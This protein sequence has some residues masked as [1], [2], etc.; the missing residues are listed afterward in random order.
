MTARTMCP[1]ETPA[2]IVFVACDVPTVPAWMVGEAGSMVDHLDPDCQHIRRCGDVRPTLD[3]VCPEGSD[4]CGTCVRRW[5]AK[6]RA[7]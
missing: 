3:R 2:G 6:A 4:L 7:S 1:H 5:R